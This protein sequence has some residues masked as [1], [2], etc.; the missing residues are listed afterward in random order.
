MT[1]IAIA[2]GIFAISAVMRSSTRESAVAIPR[3]DRSPAGVISR[4]EA[5]LRRDPQNVDALS[6]LA[7]AAL[8]R[9]KETA[10]STWYVRSEKAATAALAL[11]PT[12][13]P[14]LDAQATLANARHRFRDAIG[15]AMASRRIEPDRFAPLEM[16]TDANI[17]LG[18]YEAGFAAAE[19][20]LALR[21]D[22]ASYSRASYAAELRGE[23]EHA[24]ALMELAADSAQPASGD[25]AWARTHVG[26]L[27]FGSGDLAGAEREMRRA[28]GETPGDTVALAGLAKV[29]AAAGDLAEAAR[30]YEE[31]LD[32]SPTAPIAGE[33]AEVYAVANRPADSRRALDLAHE[34]DRREARNGV[35]LDLDAAAVE[36]NFHIP[37][38]RDVSRA[39]QGHRDRTGVV[40]D[41]ALGWVL[42]RAG[43]CDEGLRYAKRSLRIGTRDAGMYF[44]AGMAARCAGKRA[45]ATHYLTRALAINPHFSIRWAPVARAE[46]AA[47]TAR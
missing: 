5:T 42:T 3:V 21:P 28:L 34:L 36:A 33:L 46:L 43:Q 26:L 14:A 37:T 45:L 6:L 8:A 2:V 30:L 27:R 19:E 29:R 24:V 13:V 10:D 9:A 7:T 17:E 23:R 44:H 31:A 25:R 18:R 35:L 4:A 40:G 22:L 16:L 41:D 1:T 12:N 47:L 32:G 38:S 15:P 20:R 11:D 39:R